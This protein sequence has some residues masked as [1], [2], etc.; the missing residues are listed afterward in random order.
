MTAGEQTVSKNALTMAVLIAIVLT[1][2]IVGSIVFAW[3]N[4]EARKDQIFM[5]ELQ[6]QERRNLDQQMDILKGSK[7]NVESR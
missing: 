7:E 2:I 6:E 4:S 1:A 3:Q 5:Q